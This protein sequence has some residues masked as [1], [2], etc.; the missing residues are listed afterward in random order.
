[1]LPTED[2]TTSDEASSEEEEELFPSKF[3]SVSEEDFGSYLGP[4]VGDAPIL[5]LLLDYD[6]T[7]A[8]IAPRPDLAVIPGETKAVLERL[9]KRSD[10]F[11]AIV[12]GN[13]KLERAFID[14]LVANNFPLT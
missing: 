8:P 4:F 3:P 10:V 11:V 1:M 6:G 9:S 13:G 12:S 7:L 14:L 2:A 5:T